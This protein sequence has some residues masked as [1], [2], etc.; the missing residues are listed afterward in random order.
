MSRHR[1][2]NRRLA[3]VCVVALGLSGLLAG[4]AGAT[5][6]TTAAAGSVTVTSSTAAT[7]AGPS[8]AVRWSMRPD[9]AIVRDPSSGLT[10]RLAGRWSAEGAAVR[11]GLGG[12]TG[13]GTADDG[14]RLS[15]EASDFAVAARMSSER[16]PTGAGYSPNV[17]QK[18]FAASGGQWKMTLRPTARGARAACRFEGR[19]GRLTVIDRSSTSIDDGAQHDVE[20]WRQGSRFGVSV[21]GRSTSVRRRVG[22]ISP[23]T[24]TTVANKQASAGVDDQLSGSLFCVVVVTGPGSRDA[25]G[26]QLGC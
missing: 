9:G 7:T 23:R 11:F 16:V 6:L 21:D 8:T 5:A 13:L 25:A 12:G 4:A 15:P 14:R 24:P 26:A 1:R 22:A 20:C 2:P 10:L 18:G 19:T 17:V 3:P